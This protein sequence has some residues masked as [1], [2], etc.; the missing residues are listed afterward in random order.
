[1]IKMEKVSIVNYGVGNLLSVERAFEKIGCM[2]ELVSEG[3][4]ILRSK[5]LV[6]PGVG[7][8]GNGMCE[9][10][11]RGLTAPIMEYCSLNKPF[12]GI[13]LGMQ[14]MLESSEESGGIS[15]LRIISGKSDR[16][17]SVRMGEMV[18]KVPNI[19]WYSLKG[20]DWEGTIL[21]GVKDTDQFYFVHSYAAHLKRKENCLAELSYGKQIFA[22]AIRNGNCYGTQFHP[23]NSGDAGLKVLKNFIER[24]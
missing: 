23:E 17:D 4:D 7:A 8:F 6:L 11:K 15:G 19:G 18:Y 10:D 16:L 2:V 14:M 5:Y 12:L 13:C 3:K 24:I 20:R 1:M 22:A 21:E 9:L